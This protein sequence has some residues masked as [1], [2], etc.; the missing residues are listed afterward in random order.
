MLVLHTA[1]LNLHYCDRVRTS[2]PL[3]HPKT[4]RKPLLKPYKS[5]Q[6][7]ASIIQTERPK[8]WLSVTKGD[9]RTRWKPKRTR[10]PR[11]PIKNPEKRNA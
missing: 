3:V 4:M 8:I 10:N 9:T 5:D 6:I 2:K 1:M 11:I 7:I